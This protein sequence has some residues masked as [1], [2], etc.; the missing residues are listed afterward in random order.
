MIFDKNIDLS[1]Y[2]LKC[3]NC[4]SKRLRP[5][6][7]DLEYGLAFRDNGEYC[8]ECRDCSIA[9]YPKE[10]LKLKQPTKGNKT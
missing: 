6:K 8:L 5:Q 4:G 7:F 9:V 3:H 1:R 2:V 10:D